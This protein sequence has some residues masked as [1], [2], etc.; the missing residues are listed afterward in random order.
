MA[1]LV[2]SIAFV[3]L[4]DFLKSN[5]GDASID[6]VLKGVV[7][8]STRNRT[9][10]TNVNVQLLH[11]PSR[12]VTEGLSHSN[13]TAT[14]TPRRPRDDSEISRL[15]AEAISGLSSVSSNPALSHSNATASNDTAETA[16][17]RP[18]DESEVSRV[19][20]EAFSR[21]S[22][23]PAKPAVTVDERYSLPATLRPSSKPTIGPTTKPSHEPSSKPTLQPTRKPTVRPTP[24]PRPAPTAQPHKIARVEEAATIVQPVPSRPEAIL[25]RLNHVSDMSLHTPNASGIR[26]CAFGK[27]DA[28][29]CTTFG[30]SAKPSNPDMFPSTDKAR[31]DSALHIPVRGLDRLRAAYP[32]F[33]SRLKG[34]GRPVKVTVVGGS[35]TGGGNCAPRNQ[36]D[37]NPSCSWPGQ[38]KELVHRRYGSRVQINVAARAATS[39]DWSIS[40]ISNLVPRDSDIVIVD[41]VQNDDR[42]AL[43]DL[44]DSNHIDVQVSVATE[45]WLRK[46]KEYFGSKPLPVLIFFLS[47]PPPGFSTTPAFRSMWR[48]R[49]RSGVMRKVMWDHY[50]NYA[51]VLHHYGVPYVTLQSVTWSRGP[52]EMPT[53][54]LWKSTHNGQIDK[55]PDWTVHKA[56][57]D[58]VF[59]ALQVLESDSLAPPSSAANAIATN[60]MAPQ[61]GDAWPSENETF[62]PKEK[63]GKSGA[64]SG[65]MSFISAEFESSGPL[66]PPNGWRRYEDRPG[67][68]GWIAEGNATKAAEVDFV[69]R[70]GDKRTIGIEYMQSYEGMGQVDVTI[71]SLE[72][73]AHIFEQ[74]YDRRTPQQVLKKRKVHGQTQKID[75]RCTQRNSLRKTTETK[76]VCHRGGM[77][78]SLVL[79][80]FSHGQE[81]GKFKIIS[82]YSC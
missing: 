22:S 17:R 9:G 47:Y 48:D 7:T 6:K 72:G 37:R 65:Y 81:E 45:R 32:R 31:L 40:M 57:A 70:C 73:S 39:L 79:V 78:T 71:S 52:A 8:R 34:A 12:E 3:V 67:K 27:A 63:L 76:I 55:H 77:E 62:W 49:A 43:D 18:R 75:G 23:L 21:L 25:H 26:G 5:Y 59:H 20:A 14:T 35:M 54:G 41:Y 10:N 80:H 56:C 24:L 68:P 53:P 69:V 50:L 46:F 30:Q 2:A 51:Q 11:R 19:A 61:T 36:Q 58:T 74:A 44:F 64:C 66:Q 82:V 28:A 42:P 16:P 15:A 38:L 29:Y 13:A 4:F 60:T 33:E 1:F